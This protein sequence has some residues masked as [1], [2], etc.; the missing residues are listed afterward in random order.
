M[1]RGLRITLLAAVLIP[2]FLLR[3][4]FDRKA[5]PVLLRRFLQSAGAGFVKLGQILA[6]R[7]DLISAAYSEE[8]SKLFDQMPTIPFPEIQQVIESDLQRKLSDIYQRVDPI[9]LASASIAQVHS[10]VLQSGEAIVVKVCARA[11]IGD[12]R[13]IW[14]F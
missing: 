10:A 12:S 1:L 5:G 13:W 8:L 6:T 11:L 4:P 2:L 9:P 7:Y 3:R 14:R